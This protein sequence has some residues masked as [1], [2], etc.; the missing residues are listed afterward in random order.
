MFTSMSMTGSGILTVG[1]G[2]LLG[3][4]GVNADTSQISGW[5]NSAIEVAGLVMVIV[6]QF[7]RKDLSWGFWRI[8]PR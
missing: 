7:R 8:T 1:L 4:L 2:A 6:G 3:W 5:V